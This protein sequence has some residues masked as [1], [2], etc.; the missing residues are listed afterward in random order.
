MAEKCC[1]LGGCL[2]GDF[3]I[4]KGEIDCDIVFFRAMNAS[5]SRNLR[6][7]FCIVKSVCDIFSLIE[8]DLLVSETVDVVF[9][10]DF[11]RKATFIICN[12]SNVIHNRQ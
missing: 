4:R 3:Q 8:A 10:T 1:S 11:N 2:V 5:S 7:R 6:I 12:K 9:K